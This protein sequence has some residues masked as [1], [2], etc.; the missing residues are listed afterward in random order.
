VNQALDLARATKLPVAAVRE[1][2]ARFTAAAVPLMR[3][4]DPAVAANE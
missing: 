4:L 3:Y 1:P 2:L